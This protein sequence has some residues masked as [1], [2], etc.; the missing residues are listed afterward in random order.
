MAQLAE[1]MGDDEFFGAIERFAGRFE[2]YRDLLP[3]IPYAYTRT[4]LLRTPRYEV[5]AMRWSPG[6]TSP[7]HDHGDSRCW[8]LM[9]QGELAVEN[10]ECDDD[11]SGP[12]A[13]LRPT[14]NLALAAGQIDFRGGPTELHRVQNPTGEIA[15]SLQLYSEPIERYTVVDA[16]SRHRRI[17]TATCDLELLG[18]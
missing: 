7:I 11:R 10:Y 16:H 8:V 6:S 9:M 3:A 1:A 15:Y 5:V 2:S 17:V 12:L 4:L 13:A 18:R 14:G